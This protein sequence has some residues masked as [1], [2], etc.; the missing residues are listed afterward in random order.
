M[1]YIKDDGSPDSDYDD[2]M[3]HMILI[4]SAEDLKVEKLQKEDP[5]A[6]FLP[7]Y[8]PE[9]D[10]SDEIKAKIKKGQKLH[11]ISEQSYKMINDKDELYKALKDD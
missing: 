1:D 3:T 7:N 4:N 6:I 8:L 9:K 10:Y 2:K 11:K 5:D